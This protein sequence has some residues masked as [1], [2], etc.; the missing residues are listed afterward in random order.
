MEVSK[1]SDSAARKCRIAPQPLPVHLRAS[2]ASP[3][4]VISRNRPARS[5]T[6]TR[7]GNGCQRGCAITKK[8]TKK[9]RCVLARTYLF[10]RFVAS[11]SQDVAHLPRCIVLSNLPLC[12][13]VP[14]RWCMYVVY[15][16]MTYSHSNTGN[17]AIYIKRRAYTYILCRFCLEFTLDETL[18]ADFSSETEANL[19]RIA[20]N[21]RQ[22]ADGK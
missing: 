6:R 16:R 22:P 19:M 13:S 10:A 2:E 7:N 17:L 5:Y 3:V 12:R 20:S 8:K 9:L 1:A 11:A 18:I 21:N 15:I 4:S 14:H